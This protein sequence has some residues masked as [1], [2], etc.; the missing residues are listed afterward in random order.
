MTDK[1]LKNAQAWEHIREHGHEMDEVEFKS[2]FPLFEPG[3]GPAL[4]DKYGKNDDLTKNAGTGGEAIGQRIIVKG[5]VLDE[6]GN[7]VPKAFIEIWQANSAGRYIHK[8]DSWDAP[9]DPNFIGSGWTYTD[10]D[11]HYEFTTI[12]PGN[13]AWK[14]DINQW[15][16]AHIHFS[17]MGPALA[18]RL[19]TQLYFEGDP[20]LDYDE[21]IYLDLDED[22][23]KRVVATYNHDFTEPDWALGYQFDMVLRGSSASPTMPNRHQLTDEER[24]ELKD[25]GVDLIDD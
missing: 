23:R 1:K 3:P 7:P 22:E 15:R 19:V 25:K 2:F 16:P 11:G 6:D 18:D 13:Y 9:L 14:P 20:L 10:E 8:L 5:R 4:V 12:K 17:V 21:G 24:Q